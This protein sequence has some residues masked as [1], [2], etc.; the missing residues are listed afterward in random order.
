MQ[1]NKLRSVCP[2]S[3]HFWKDCI[4]IFKKCLNCKWHRCTIAISWS[5]KKKFTRKKIKKK[6][7]EGTKRT[8]ELWKSNK[9]NYKRKKKTSVFK[10]IKQKFIINI[11]LYSLRSRRK[12]FQPRN[13]CY[14]TKIFNFWKKNKKKQ[15]PKRAVVPC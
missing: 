9:N 6:T 13:V 5:P 12:H 8:Y 14:N 15:I 1:C 4:S 7:K 2:A 10:Y 11:S 3:V